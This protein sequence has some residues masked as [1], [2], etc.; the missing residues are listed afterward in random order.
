MAGIGRCRANSGNIICKNVSFLW[1]NFLSGINHFRNLKKFSCVWTFF[2]R[3]D[4]N[5]LKIGK[6]EKIVIGTKV[7]KGDF[8][9]AK[10]ITDDKSSGEQQ[11]WYFFYY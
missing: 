2:D 11:N 1:F 8:F 3:V 10:C 9:E 5:T 6:T 7:E 4:D